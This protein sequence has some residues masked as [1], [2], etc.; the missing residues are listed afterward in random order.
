V[1][2]TLAEAN[3]IVDVAIAKAREFN[4]TVSVAVCD[5]LGHLIA[6]NRMDGVYGEANRF[7]IGKAVVSAGTGLPSGEVEAIVDHFPKWPNRGRTRSRRSVIP[8]TRGGVC[9]RWDCQHPTVKKQAE[10]S[11]PRTRG[12]RNRSGSTG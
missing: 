12:A 2:L 8:R 7:S 5:N 4:I 11:R 10:A 6:L 1:T 3:S 9:S